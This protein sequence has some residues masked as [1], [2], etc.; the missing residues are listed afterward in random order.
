MKV[1][2]LL[3]SLQNIAPDSGSKRRLSSC[4]ARL[5]KDEEQILYDDRVVKLLEKYVRKPEWLKKQIAYFN[6]CDED[7]VKFARSAGS[8]NSMKK[9]W[10]GFKAEQKPDFRW[11]NRCQRAIRKVGD[12]YAKAALTMIACPKSIDDLRDL[13]A[14][15]STS[16]GWESI[17][18]G[19]RT[20]G[21]LLSEESY[22]S[23]W[24]QSL[25]SALNEG[26]FTDPIVPGYRTQCSDL[27][28]GKCKHKKRP[29]NMVTLKVILAESLYANPLSQWLKYYQYTAIGKDT[30]TDISNWVSQQRKDMYQWLSLDYSAYDSSIPSWLIDAAF[31]IIR[32]AFRNLGK[33]GNDLLTVLKQTFIVKDIIT[34]EGIIHATH[35]NPSGSKFTAII[36]GICNEIM[37]EYWAD[38]LGKEVEYMIMGDDNL[39]FAKHVGP[40]SPDEVERISSVLLSK[41]GVTVNAQKSASGTHRDSPEFLSAHWTAF[42]PW[43]PGSELY[44]HLAYPERFRDYR[45][46][47]LTPQMLIYSY[48][49]AYPAGM[50]DMMY[51][52]QFLRDYQAEFSRITWVEGVT[53][54]LPYIVRQKLELQRKA[55]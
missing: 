44:S 6:A 19:L 41:F 15:K 10:D 27:G 23:S 53:K 54:S 21:E 14:D 24:R 28:G 34:P 48:I 11:N 45:A 42:G 16:G 18:T 40:F 3:N 8:Y 33:F 37:T 30:R 2:K 13:V 4:I 47:K 46:G 17:L 43:R 1:A 38:L 25:E 39:I 35:G 50:R 51:I 32:G 9:V 26:R 22:Y 31:E 5:K 36:N 20:K 55:G 49:L 29:I 52:D 12:R 7:G